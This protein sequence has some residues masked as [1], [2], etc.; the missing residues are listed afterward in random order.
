MAYNYEIVKSETCNFTYIRH[1]TFTRK[2]NKRIL[3][4]ISTKKSEKECVYVC[5]GVLVMKSPS[6]KN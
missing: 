5:E 2:N 1:N 3:K 6:V 4:K